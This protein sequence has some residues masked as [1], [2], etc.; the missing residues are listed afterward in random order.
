MKK[1][2]GSLLF[3]LSLYAQVPYTI[4]V[5]TQTPKVHEPVLLTL[6]YTSSEKDNL[7]WVKFQPQTSDA[8]TV[9]L[10]S[11]EETRFTYVHRFILFPL[12]SGDIPLS[13]SLSYQKDTLKDEAGLGQ[14]GKEQSDYYQ[15]GFKKFN[16]S[17]VMLHVGK[18]PYQGKFTLQTHFDKT[19]ISAYEPVYLSI[20]LK[21][22]GYPPQKVLTFPEI[23]GVKV[24]K[25]K[26]E[27]HISYTPDGAHC[28]YVFNYALIATN[29]FT[30]PKISVHHLTTTPQNIHVLPT[31]T[32]VDKTDNPPRFEPFYKDLVYLLIFFAGALSGYL[33]SL[34]RKQKASRFVS[35]KEAKD[36]KTLIRILSVQYPR[37]F[38]DMIQTLQE[39]ENTDL[40]NI[41]KEII[42]R[43]KNA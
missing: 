18:T 20:T 11:K 1:L 9:E 17:P 5:S 30:V 29:D 34:Y 7:A 25:D 19:H 2:L 13:L 12:Q 32:K 43:L 27:I 21:G 28:L 8:Y 40:K 39:K 31:T 3:S 33:F 42:Q 14:Q 38:E 36:A 15:S 26:P 41:K 22:V 10:L 16:I 37:M 24:L 6:R 4:E 35:I 23:K